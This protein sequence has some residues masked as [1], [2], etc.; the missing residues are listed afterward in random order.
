[1][2]KAAYATEGVDSA[3]VESARNRILIH[4][5]KLTMAATQF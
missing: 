2:R 3:V 4:G 5:E 1:M